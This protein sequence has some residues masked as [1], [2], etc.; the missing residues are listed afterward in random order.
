M[1]SSGYVFP[2]SAV[3]TRRLIQHYSLEW[4]GKKRTPEDRRPSCWWLKLVMALRRATASWPFRNGR[5]EQSLPARSGTQPDCGCAG[6]ASGHFFRSGSRLRGLLCN[7]RSSSLGETARASGGDCGDCGGNAVVMPSVVEL[8]G[9]SDVA[10]F[11]E[12]GPV[13]PCP[14]VAGKRPCSLNTWG[15]WIV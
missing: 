13:C 11:S 10:L 12:N 8:T 7:R 14:T 2:L 1:E 9:V 3:S 5:G 4:R 6:R 15:E